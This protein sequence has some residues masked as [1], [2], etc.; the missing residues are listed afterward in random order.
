MDKLVGEQPCFGIF[1]AHKLRVYYCTFYNITRFLIIN[2][3]ISKAKQSRAFIRGFQPNLWSRIAARLD[4][5]FPDHH[6]D[7][8]YKLSDIHDAAN[9]ILAGTATS[10]RPQHIHPNG[11]AL[12]ALN[13]ATTLNPAPPA[14][15]APQIK[16]ED[17]L[18]I[19]G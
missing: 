2:N 16:T 14:V 11:A 17:F 10:A 8:A 4:I 1:S 18:A 5:K 13:T 12:L 15:P 6:P 9:H 3:C 7:N 19:L